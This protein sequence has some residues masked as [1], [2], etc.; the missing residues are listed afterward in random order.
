MT[1][2]EVTRYD[3]GW[4]E[5]WAEADLQYWA[6]QNAILLDQISLIKAE[7]AKLMTAINSHRTKYFRADSLFPAADR[8]GALEA[9][10]ARLRRMLELKEQ[11]INLLNEDTEGMIGLAFAHGWRCPDRIVLRGVELREQ[12]DAIRKELGA[13]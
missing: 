5:H 4:G 3:D 9:E 7:N 13:T 12:M 10:N 2:K 6:R 8:L 1:L 11:Y